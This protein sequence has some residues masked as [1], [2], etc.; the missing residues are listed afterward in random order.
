MLNIAILVYLEN[1]N[2]FLPR[3][4]RA[5][6]GYMGNWIELVKERQ[7]TTST[8]QHTRVGEIAGDATFKRSLQGLQ[9]GGIYMSRGSMKNAGL[10]NTLGPARSRNAFDGHRSTISSYGGVGFRS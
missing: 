4:I 2:V 7:V 5:Q 10:T 8:M 6:I 3:G 9:N 1:Q